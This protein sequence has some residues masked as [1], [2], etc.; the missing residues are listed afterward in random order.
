MPLK[1]T[2][3]KVPNHVASLVKILKKT[4]KFEIAMNHVDELSSTP[5]KMKF[6]WNHH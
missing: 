5:S 1:A 2:D 6:C 3:Y 4:L